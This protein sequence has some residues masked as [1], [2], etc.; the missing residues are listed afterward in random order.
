MVRCRFIHD[1]G[2]GGNRESNSS[3]ARRGSGPSCRNSRRH[4]VG[5]PRARPDQGAATTPANPGT[6]QAVRPVSRLLDS[7]SLPRWQGTS[8]WRYPRADDTD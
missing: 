5:H 7:A 8:R 3:S 1:D 4:L 2:E 6:G